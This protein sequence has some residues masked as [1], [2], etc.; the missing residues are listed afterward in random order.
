MENNI[1]WIST[2]ALLIPKGNLCSFF[3]YFLQKSNLDFLSTA[4]STVPY[5]FNQDVISIIVAIVTNW[6]LRLNTSRELLLQVSNCFVWWC[7]FIHIQILVWHD[8]N[9]F[10]IRIPYLYPNNGII[11][12][13]RKMVIFLTIIVA[14]LHVF[15]S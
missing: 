1:L 15:W 10:I 8:I 4:L 14:S 9:I 13:I 11:R 2:L 5:T 7:S 6:K 3:R 12:N